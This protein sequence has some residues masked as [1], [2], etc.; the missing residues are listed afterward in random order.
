MK[1][2]AI[3]ARFSGLYEWGKGWLSGDIAKKW[4]EYFHALNSSGDRCFWKYVGRDAIWGECQ[5]LVSTGGSIYLHPLQCNYVGSSSVDSYRFD[6]GKRV[7]VFP[8]I[9]ELR[10]ILIGAAKACGG[11]VEFSDVSTANVPIP[12]WEGVQWPK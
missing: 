1:A 6:A 11:Q 8:E 10:E 3:R 9:E 7:E 2:I 4:N 5:H 12:E